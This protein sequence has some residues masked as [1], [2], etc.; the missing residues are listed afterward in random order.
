[1][2]YLNLR[3]LYITRW[4]NVQIISRNLYVDK[5]KV[6]RVKELAEQKNLPSPTYRQKEFIGCICYFLGETVDVSLLLMN[7]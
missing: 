6:R 2:R 4:S 1:M 7:R 5:V 3:R